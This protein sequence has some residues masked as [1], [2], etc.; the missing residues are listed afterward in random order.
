MKS[1]VDSSMQEICC[2]LPSNAKIENS[3]NMICSVGAKDG[4]K[5]EAWKWHR[6]LAHCSA[7][8]VRFA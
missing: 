8:I 4:N 6:R 3:E 2:I 1:F 7:K 5:D